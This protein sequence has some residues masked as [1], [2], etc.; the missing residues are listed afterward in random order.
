MSVNE[1]FPRV[2]DL[3]MQQPPSLRSRLAWLGRCGLLIQNILM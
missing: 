2:C 3:L 1:L